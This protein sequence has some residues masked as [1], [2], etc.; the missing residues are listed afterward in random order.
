AL[1]HLAG[2]VDDL[3]FLMAMHAPT[4][5]HSAGQTMQVSGFVVP[6][7]PSVGA[8]VSYALGS[9]NRNLPTFVALPD[10]VGLPWTGQARGGGGFR[11]AQ[12]RPTMFQPAAETPVP[13]LFPPRP[14]RF[15]TRDGERAG[16]ALLAELNRQQQQRTPGDSRLEARI[17][18]Y[19]L[20]ARMQL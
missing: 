1:P 5:E 10:P 19:E 14:T 7:F 8:W 15:A 16:L 2:C 6:G 20:A 4:S 17:R 11:P 9:L 18:S 3:A 13:A 12:H